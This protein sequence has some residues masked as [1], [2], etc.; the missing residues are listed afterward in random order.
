MFEER[1]RRPETDSGYVQ[2][3]L[4]RRVSGDVDHLGVPVAEL[5]AVTLDDRVGDCRDEGLLERVGQDR[6]AEVAREELVAGRVI[7][8]TMRRE[9]RDDLDAVTPHHLERLRHVGPRVD[10][11]AATVLAPGDQPAID[12]PPRVLHAIDDHSR[13]LP[14]VPP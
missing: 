10:E 11:D 3:D 4:A 6:R 5:E 9:D 13:P 7:V 12:E 8:V 2:P 14:S 1:V